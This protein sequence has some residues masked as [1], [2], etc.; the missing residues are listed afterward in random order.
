MNSLL[1]IFQTLHTYLDS[2]TSTS[3]Q[4]SI[5][6]ANVNVS[7]PINNI[8]GSEP[9]ARVNNVNISVPQPVIDVTADMPIDAHV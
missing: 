4:Q 5:S 2:V 6:T 9:S 3:I 8:L 1:L 7:S